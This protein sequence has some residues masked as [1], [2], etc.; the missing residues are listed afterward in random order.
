MLDRTLELTS[1]TGTSLEVM[2]SELGKFFT[3]TGT[4][5]ST[6]FFLSNDGEFTRKPNK[7]KTDFVTK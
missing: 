3:I 7:N 1:D 6:S 5:S 2:T 4:R